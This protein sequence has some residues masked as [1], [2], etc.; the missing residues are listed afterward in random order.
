[1]S[2]SS[3]TQKARSRRATVNR[4]TVPGQC[5]ECAALH[6]QLA[7]A[8]AALYAEHEC[9]AYRVVC[10]RGHEYEFLLFA[11]LNEAYD[12]CADFVDAADWDVKPEPLYVRRLAKKSQKPLDSPGDGARMTS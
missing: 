5:S 10:P 3:G 8:K 7:D 11:A 9:V 2:K 6:E 4:H 12:Q 1:M